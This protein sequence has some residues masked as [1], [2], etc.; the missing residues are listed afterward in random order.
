MKVDEDKATFKLDQQK[1]ELEQEVALGNI[2]N[3]QK[4]AK[5]VSFE[6]EMYASKRAAML[7][8]LA[9]LQDGTTAYAEQNEKILKLE[10]AHQ[11]ALTKLANQGVLDREQY[12]LQADKLVE[13][14]FSTLFSDLV[15]R[16][17]TAKQAFTDFI[18]SITDGLVKIAS[19]QVAQ[20]WFGA[21]SQGGSAISGIMSKIFGGNTA[22]LGGAAG[23][24]TEAA[25]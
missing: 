20:Q 6:N 2:T 18:K 4:L 17:K 1:L 13:S 23:A 8:D 12:A 22:G 3:A 7:K 25:H 15:D 11:L 14:S 21:G 10:E 19:N 24:G 9:V 16:T 5:E